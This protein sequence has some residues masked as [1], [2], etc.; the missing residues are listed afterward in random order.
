[1]ERMTRKPVSKTRDLFSDRY[2]RRRDRLSPTFQRVAGYIDRNRLTVLTSSAIEI[3]R[4]VG[5]SDA[6]VVRAVQALGFSGLQEL[7]RELAAS[8]GQRTSPAENLKRTLEDAEK[9][10]DTVP[11]RCWRSMRRGLTCCVRRGFAM[12]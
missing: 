5:T 9:Q 2:Q 1:M 6:T 4:A 7:R 8:L 12:N 3:A 11:M 10:M